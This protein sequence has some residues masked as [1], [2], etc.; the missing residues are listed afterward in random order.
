MAIF[1]QAAIPAQ[2]AAVGI[3]TAYYL[4]GDGSALAAAAERIQEWFRSP[5]MEI[6]SA[7]AARK[8]RQEERVR[9]SNFSYIFE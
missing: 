3:N 5:Q 7:R 9:E 2:P 6:S 8:S 1:P 4:Q